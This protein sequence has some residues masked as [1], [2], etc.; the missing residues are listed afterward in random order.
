MTTHSMLGAR[1]RVYRIGR[2]ATDRTNEG[3]A[4]VRMLE[5]RYMH[6]LAGRD[7][8][9]MRVMERALTSAFWVIRPKFGYAFA[10][11]PEK[12][13]RLLVQRCTGLPAR[14]G[15]D[16]KLLAYSQGLWTVTKEVGRR[17]T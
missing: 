12:P 16:G 17:S 13:N 4:E 14:K 7:A 9:I 11:I 15:I 1:K 3:S 5:I 10:C 6:S 2:H 8:C